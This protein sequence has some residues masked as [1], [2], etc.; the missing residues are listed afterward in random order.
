MGSGVGAGGQPYRKEF[1][2]ER[3]WRKR[4]DLTLK[5]PYCNG[6]P[7]YDTFSSNERGIP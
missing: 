5:V 6:I 7:S 4:G 3:E 2:W 1:W